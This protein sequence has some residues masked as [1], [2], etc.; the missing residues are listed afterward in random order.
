VV[1]LAR[2]S[3]SRAQ[4]DLLG[5][6]GLDPGRQRQV[7]VGQR[8]HRLL[9][10]PP[11]RPLRPLHERTEQLGADGEIDGLDRVGLGLLAEVAAP[12]R[13]VVDPRVDGEA[14]TPERLRREG[15]GPPVVDVVAEGD[16][17]PA[18]TTFRLVAHHG[19]EDLV[20][21]TDEVGRDLDRL[22]D[23][24][25]GREPAV[26]DGRSDPLD[27]HPFPR[28]HVPLLLV[29]PSARWTV[30]CEPGRC[31]RVPSVG[32]LPSRPRRTRRTRS[33]VSGTAT[34]LLGQFTEEHAERIVERL[35]EAGI[36]WW[37]KRTSGLSRILFAGDWGT[38]VFVDEA[39]GQEAAAIVREV[40]GD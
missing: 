12:G 32:R 36:V 24:A 17:R 35:E 26:E 29:G 14:V 20:G 5:E 16:L 28:R 19:P 34:V 27:A 9:E 33:A 2:G 13:H 18:P 22:A 38:R 39:R 11:R 8:G 15:R 10:P 25:L 4:G 40:V 1:L 30:V 6:A 3:R 37:V 23:D 31:P 7:D 21:V